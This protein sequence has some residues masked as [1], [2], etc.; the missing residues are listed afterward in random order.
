MGI[1]ATF[2]A[3]ADPTRREILVILRRGDMTAGEIA[4]QFDL[5][6]STLSG[7]CNVLREAG[8]IVSERNRSTVV[9]SIN[10]SAF[11]EAAAAVIAL[12]SHGESGHDRNGTS[13]H[14]P[15]EQEN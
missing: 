3:L 8:L 1:N 14:H 11:D 4:E 9:Y 5:S 2:R 12:F 6:R 15:T 7:H 13:T 10:T